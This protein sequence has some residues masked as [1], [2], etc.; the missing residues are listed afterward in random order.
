MTKPE[1]D[2]EGRVPSVPEIDAIVDCARWAPTGDNVQQFSFDWDGECLGVLED[3]DRSRAF[4]NV[5]NFASHMALGMC[6][7]TIE[8]GAEQNGW[9]AQWEFVEEGEFVARVTFSEVA[10]RP[11]PLGEAIRSRTVDRR[12]YLKDP[13]SPRY[14]EEIMGMAQNPW[15]IRFHLLTEP[16]RVGRMAKINGMFESFMFEHRRIHDFFYRWFRRTDAEAG[17]T[18]DG[19]PLSTMGIGPLAAFGVRVMAMW[20]VARLF[21]L[22]GFTRLAA[23]R[24]ERL[25]RRSAALGFLPFRPLTPFLLSAWAGYGNACG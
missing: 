15:G 23:V 14:A 1:N 6:L 5:G 16:K 24:A 7:S 25:Y 4:L 18:E 12:P 13:V 21:A 10:I 9:L 22:L 19:L 3:L 8:I 11:S 20:G 17:R 2:I